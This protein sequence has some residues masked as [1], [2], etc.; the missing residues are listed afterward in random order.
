MTSPDRT[1]SRAHTNLLMTGQSAFLFSAGKLVF[2]TT[3][4]HRLLDKIETGGASW[5]KL[6]DH[7]RTHNPEICDNIETLNR[8]GSSFQSSFIDDPQHRG[9]DLVGQ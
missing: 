2:A 7:F 3:D 4:G 1:N 9:S 8:E 5:D 6:S